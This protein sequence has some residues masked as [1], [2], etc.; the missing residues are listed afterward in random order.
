MSKSIFQ[1]ID[2]SVSGGRTS[3]VLS[4]NTN[5]RQFDL[6]NGI[7]PT[8]LHLALAAY[9]G[10]KNYHCGLFS[11]AT[12]L[13]P[14]N[15]PQSTAGSQNPFRVGHNQSLNSITPILRDNNHKAVLIVQYSDLLAPAAEGSVFL[16]PEQ[17]VLLETL[18]RWG[19]DDAIKQSQNIVILISY[20]SDVN[21]LLTRS[22]AYTSIQ[23]PLPD[24]KMRRDFINLMLSLKNGLTQKFAKLEEG[25]SVE[26]MVRKS[27]GLRIIDIETL[28]RLK[29]D[30][31]IG[32]SDIQ[33]MKS[34]TINEMAGGLVEVVE[35]NQG[36]EAIAGL[37]SVKEYFLR[38]KWNFQNG[39]PTVPYALVLAG[40]PGTGKS[41]LCGTLAKELDLP[42]LILRNLY[43]SYVGQ[44]EA[45]LERVLHVVE[46]M[47]PCVIVIEEIDQSI[48]QRGTGS[49]GDSGTSNRMSQR[50][51]EYLGSSEKNRG[52]NLWIGTSNR[53]D[54]L[55]E[56]MRDRFQ[57][58]LPFLHPNP[59]EVV[60]LLPELAKQVNREI[61][62]S[63]DLDMI[64]KL[65]NLYLPTVRGLNEIISAAAQRADYES[66]NIG[67][68]IT[69][70]HLEDAA[71]DYKS[72]YDPLQHE[73]IA[74][75]AIELVKFTSLLPWMSLDGKR[76]DAEIPSY[77]EHIVD[78]STGKVDIMKLSQ[79]IRELQQAIYQQKAMR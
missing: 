32:R 62:G 65:P 25:F 70:Q 52:K 6:E 48:G 53:P 11:Q 43:G 15:P 73:F 30:T 36:F 54:L 27:N 67:T 79:R 16:Q 41:K 50:F 1:Q 59:K 60:Q 2:E 26:E 21:S 5:D 40:V 13:T 75:K 4:W 38:L 12:G 68:P 34:K 17:Q 35:P 64:S 7:N 55:D 76:K 71:N 14:I 8:S 61:N 24:E 10:R 19:T 44:S 63:I 9:F 42:L 20:E 69:Q 39:S 45:N 56:A 57:V 23:V 74:L 3:F 18:H 29:T 46:S 51:W 72:T 33:M 37:P 66:G 77:L 58:V 22:G 78:K 49:G 31:T 28:F 47:S